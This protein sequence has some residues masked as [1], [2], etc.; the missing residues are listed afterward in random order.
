MH[1]HMYLHMHMHMHMHMRV[2]GIGGREDAGARLVVALGEVL[3]DPVDLLR[4]ARQAKEGEEEAQRLVKGEGREVELG[5]EGAQDGDGVVVGAA[6]EVADLVLGEL[7]GGEQPARQ[8]AVA[9]RP[10]A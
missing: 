6:E 3:H 10:P 5:E 7:A 1:M 2:R 4:L 8:L 9:V